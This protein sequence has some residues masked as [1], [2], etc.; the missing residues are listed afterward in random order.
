MEKSILN[1][2]KGKTIL[3]TGGTGS[4]G[5]GLVKQLVKCKPRSIRILSNDENSIF[6]ARNHLGKNQVF[7]FLMGD[8]R[9]KDRMNF[10]M[11]GADI[12]FHVAAMKHVDICESDPFE[13]VKTNV[14]GTSNV[15]EV[16]LLQNISKV[17]F[18]STDKATNPTSTLG[19]S[20]LLGERLTTKAGSL[21][22]KGKTNF[23]VVRFGNVIGSRGSVFQIFLNQIKN[24]EPLTVTDPNMT[25]F[26]M[27]ISDAASTILKATYKA[28]DGEIFI[29]KMPSVKILDLAQEMKNVYKKKMPHAKINSKIIISTVREGERMHEFLTTSDEINFCHSEGNFYKINKIVNKK[30]INDKE[31]GSETAQKVTGIKLQKIIEELM[32]EFG[33]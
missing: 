15:L 11:R 5:L 29:L 6:E 19:A 24:N 7:T 13:T 25:R 33:I 2:F 20:K 8:I 17:I 30:R 21:K 14:M 18:I 27:S 12:V 31:L 16:A 3:I 32:N 23:L 10:A 26:I 9:D 1:E 4:I 22:G 28:K